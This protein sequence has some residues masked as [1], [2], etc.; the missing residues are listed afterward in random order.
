VNTF[1]QQCLSSDYHLTRSG[2]FFSKEAGVSFQPK[3]I[4]N[5]FRKSRAIDFKPVFLVKGKGALF[6]PIVEEDWDF[7]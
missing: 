6:I 7:I 4:E 5:K 1:S 3:L 2:D